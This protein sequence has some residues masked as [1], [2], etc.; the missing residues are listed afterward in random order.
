MYSAMSASVGYGL[1]MAAT[2]H[3]TAARNSG[4]CASRTDMAAVAACAFICV[5]S[6]DGTSLS[7]ARI[8]TFLHECGYACAC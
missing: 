6:G 8:H 7:A 2:A 3:T 5:I 1:S 4:R